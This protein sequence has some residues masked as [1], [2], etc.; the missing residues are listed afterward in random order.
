VRNSVGS[1]R[2]GGTRPWSGCLG[3]PHRSLHRLCDP[4]NRRRTWARR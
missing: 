3:W 4:G 2:G 1:G